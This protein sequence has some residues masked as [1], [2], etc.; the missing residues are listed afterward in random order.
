MKSEGGGGGA[1]KAKTK[2]QDCAEQTK[3]PVHCLQKEN[4]T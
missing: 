3:T 2:M 1:L 4:L